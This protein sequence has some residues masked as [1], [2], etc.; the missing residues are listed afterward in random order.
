MSYRKQGEVIQNV[1][2]ALKKG[3]GLNT[4]D[5]TAELMIAIAKEAKKSGKGDLL[6]DDFLYFLDQEQEKEKNNE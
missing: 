2:I 3:F 1:L 5:Y 6:R 4:A